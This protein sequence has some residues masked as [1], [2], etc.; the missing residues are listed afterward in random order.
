MISMVE[1]QEYMSVGYI[2]GDLSGNRW[3]SFGNR[4]STV[5]RGGR[6]DDEYYIMRR[7]RYAFMAAQPYAYAEAVRKTL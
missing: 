6:I 5:N 7:L 3:F 4:W 1:C 2:N